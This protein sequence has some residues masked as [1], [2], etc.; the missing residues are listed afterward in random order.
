MKNSVRLSACRLYILSGG[1]LNIRPFF[2]LVIP[3]WLCQE[4]LAEGVQKTLN[5]NGFFF[6]RQTARRVR[7]DNPRYKVGR[8]RQMKT[9]I[10]V[11]PINPVPSVCDVNR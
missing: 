6:Q 1:V 11:Y 2:I 10:A 4:G 8:I 5:E 7:K 3:V 9:N